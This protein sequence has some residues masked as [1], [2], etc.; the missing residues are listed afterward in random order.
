MLAVIS[1]KQ[2]LSSRIWAGILF[3]AL[4]LNLKS[5]LLCLNM[6]PNLCRCPSHSQGHQSACG[7]NK[8]LGE[9]MSQKVAR[10]VLSSS[11]YSGS[12]ETASF[13]MLTPL[14]FLCLLKVSCHHALEYPG[15]S[16][17]HDTSICKGVYAYFL[18][19]LKAS[20][21]LHSSLFLIPFSPSHLYSYI[22]VLANPNSN[23]HTHT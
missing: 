15:C 2:V 16:A 7:A 4:F 17:V 11:G 10:P 20:I 13:P 8:I 22:Q 18:A 5:T 12:R 3:T 1:F 19:I 21:Q 9:L 23:T 14:F 6:C